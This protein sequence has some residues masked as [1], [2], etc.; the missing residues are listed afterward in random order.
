ML[1]APNESVYSTGQRNSKPSYPIFIS[2]VQYPALAQATCYI[3]AEFTCHIASV[4]GLSLSLR[5]L[6]SSYCVKVLP[7]CVLYS[8]TSL[9][10]VQEKV[11]MS[12]TTSLFAEGGIAL[13]VCLHSLFDWSC[14]VHV[15]QFL[16]Y[17]FDTH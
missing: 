8:G 6:I 2:V 10:S 15:F 16:P 11:S 14:A 13:H 7:Q 9:I 12:S 3:D 17:V 1:K 4:I 5:C